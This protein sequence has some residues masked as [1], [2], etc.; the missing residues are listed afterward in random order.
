MLQSQKKQKQKCGFLIMVVLHEVSSS[1]TVSSQFFAWKL[2]NSYH[3]T[4][5]KN[6][7]FRLVSVDFLCFRIFQKALSLLRILV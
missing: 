5:V 4:Y 1:L 3:S 7:P 6:C 2:T